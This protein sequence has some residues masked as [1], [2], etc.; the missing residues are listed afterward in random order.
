MAP[1]RLSTLWILQ[2][3]IYSIEASLRGKN[4]NKK[5]RERGVGEILA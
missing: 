4:E 3:F 2:R 5:E 1:R